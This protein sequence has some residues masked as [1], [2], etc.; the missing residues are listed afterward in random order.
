[1]LPGQIIRG[2]MFLKPLL[3]K[4]SLYEPL[5]RM[6]DLSLLQRVLIL[7]A[8]ILA[9]AALVLLIRFDMRRTAASAASHRVELNGVNR[10]ATQ[11]PFQRGPAIYPVGGPKCDGLAF[12]PSTRSMTCS[13]S[14]SRT[15]FNKT[16]DRVQQEW[17]ARFLSDGG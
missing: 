17:F 13:S 2:A 8:A 14:A 15:G 11:V 9:V 16:S 6:P 1:L 4:C 5:D 10:G 12:L 7:V 3:P